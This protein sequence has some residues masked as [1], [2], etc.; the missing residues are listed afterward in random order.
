MDSVQ[1]V[2]MKS[3]STLSVFRVLFCM[4]ITRTERKMYLTDLIVQITKSGNYYLRKLGFMMADIK[5]AKCVFER[6]SFW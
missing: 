6:K 2:E 5:L 1:L 4:Y 3:Q